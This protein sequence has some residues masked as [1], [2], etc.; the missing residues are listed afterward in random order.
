MQSMPPLTPRGKPS[1]AGKFCDRCGTPMRSD[2]KGQTCYAC[3]SVCQRCGEP[4]DHRANWCRSC[5][6]HDGSKVTV[7]MLT[8]EDLPPGIAESS[9]PVQ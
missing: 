3:S 9:G 1:T 5:S 6:N 4:K 2:R 7:M 8:E